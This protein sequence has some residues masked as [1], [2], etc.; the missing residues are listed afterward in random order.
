MAPGGRKYKPRGNVGA[1]GSIHDVYAR[2]LQ[3]ASNGRVKDTKETIVTPKEP[4]DAPL[5]RTS[6]TLPP[7][8]EGSS[9]SSDAQVKLFMWDFNQCDKKRCT[10]RKMVH[11]GHVKPMRLGQTFGGVVLSP[12]GRSKLSLE[13]L[14]I[15]LSRGLA[16]IDCSWNKVDSVNQGQLSVKHARVLPFLIA[17]NPTHYGRPFELSCVEA[18]AGALYI[19]GLEKDAMRILSSFGW[20]R[21]FIDIN[22]NNLAL[23]RAEGLTS[24]AMDEL[25]QRFLT[26][27]AT[28]NA[29][30]RAARQQ[31]DYQDIGSESPIQD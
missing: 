28:E 24:S 15:V 5:E 22:A 29:E 16:V 6:D 12:F 11:L 8:D 31:L 17:A 19:L 21:S 30:R 2:A 26:E 7:L 14:E 9:V 13:D 1:T 3:L 25:E 20:G 27:V 4:N 23:Y 10:G 18:L